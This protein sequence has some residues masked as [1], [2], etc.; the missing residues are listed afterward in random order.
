VHPRVGA[1]DVEALVET[2]LSAI[3]GGTGSE[4]AMALLWRE[5]KFLRVERQPTLAGPSGKIQHLRAREL[6]PRP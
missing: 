2:F 4:R 3:G 5:S 6:P 1:V